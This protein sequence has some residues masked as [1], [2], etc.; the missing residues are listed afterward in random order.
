MKLLKLKHITFNKRLGN[1][2][3]RSIE[4]PYVSYYQGS[5]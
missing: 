2:I 5:A 1:L 4:M 3:S